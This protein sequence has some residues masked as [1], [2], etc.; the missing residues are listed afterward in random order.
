M[1]CA[2][3]DQQAETEGGEQ[4]KLNPAMRIIITHN[5]L[6]PCEQPDKHS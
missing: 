1:I 5:L 3:A 2:V 4:G 6:S